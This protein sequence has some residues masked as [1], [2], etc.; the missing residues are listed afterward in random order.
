M[1]LI[2]R[3]QQST[4]C[5]ERVVLRCAP[6]A[7]LV[8]LRRNFARF[9]VPISLAAF[10]LVLVVSSTAAQLL[11][12]AMPTPS[13]CSAAKDNADCR[14]WAKLRPA[15]SAPAEARLGYDVSYLSSHPD[16]AAALR[17][18]A[19][20]D[21]EL[22]DY[23]AAIRAGWRALQA[24]PDNRDIETELANILAWDHQY[25]AAISLYQN[26]L[27]EKPGDRVALESLAKV[28]RWTGRLN[29]SLRVEEMLLKEAPSNPQYQ[30]QIARLEIGLH[31]NAR[32]RKFLSE[33]L[34]VHP[35]DRDAC[36]E[37]AELDMSEGKLRQAATEFRTLLGQNFQDA[38]ALYGAARI[39]YY[40]GKL[41]RALPLAANLVNERPADTD[42]LL[43]MA[44]IDR[45]LHKRKQAVA[46][47]ERVSQ[48]DSHN[49]EAGILRR[50]IHEDS[51]VSVQTSA[52][53]AREVSVTNPSFA[54]SGFPLPGRTTEDLNTYGAATRVNFG[55]LPESSSYFLTAFTPSNS[56][57]GGIQGAVAPSQFLYGQSTEVAKWLTIRGGAGLVR[58]GP[59]GV[60]MD[61]YMVRSSAIIPV[62]YLG[63]TLVLSPKLSIDVTA[64]RRAIT[65]TPLSTRFGVTQTRIEAGIDYKFDSR[66]QAELRVFHDRDFSPWYYQTGIYQGTFYLS[67]LTA[68]R[69]NGHD[70]GTGGQFSF[71]RNL[72]H[73]ERVSLDAGYSGTAF[74]YAGQSRGVF[75][76]FFNP[77]F[78]QQ[79][80]ITGRV[81]GKVWGPVGYS[82]MAG[83]GVQ[84]TGES[85]PFTLAE[86]IGPGLTLQV[87]R[88]FSVS[89]SYL[90][91][92]FAESLGSLK[93]NQVQFST[94]YHF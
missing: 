90:H 28:Y 20:A 23:S 4:W 52:S 42:A 74:S 58:I 12:Q 27:R 15:S 22:K 33:L 35:L 24:N 6:S 84:Q 88:A 89:L 5:V 40:E 39:A 46:L 73:S 91:Y 10:F 9:T 61:G 83:A 86:K 92:N 34:K 19:S 48:L 3:R 8:L 11:P 72:I 62:G 75:M 87:S 31:E 93:G 65:Y 76:G 80:L 41:H 59:G 79:H 47:L 56:P 82:L 44:R 17:E 64:A 85:Q 81:D 30:L 77:T 49:P 32:A 57:V 50:A 94:D 68:L 78:Y 16:A 29:E 45:A 69:E 60:L 67:A 70:W 66:T 25:N 71:T 2:L 54:P 36:L 53:Y 38:D 55:L 7:W 51:T 26:M 63:S 13:R 14:Y 21:G 18:A 43:L 1:Q 37:V